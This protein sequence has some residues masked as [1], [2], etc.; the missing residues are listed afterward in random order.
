VRVIAREARLALVKGQLGEQGNAVEG[1]LA[2]EHDVVAERFDLQPRE[3]F[4][5]AF[6]LLQADNVR[7]ALLQPCHEVFE[8][9][10]D[11][12]DVP[13]SNTDENDPDSNPDFANSGIP[14]AL[15]LW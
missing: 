14:S 3:G 7:R 15:R 11:R 1:F 10:P 9:L 12:I 6:G 2:V 5:G 13:R 4:I 8:P